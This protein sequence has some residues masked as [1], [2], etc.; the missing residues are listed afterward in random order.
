M[1]I[2]GSLRDLLVVELQILHQAESVLRKALPKIAKAASRPDI[3]ERLRTYQN[4]TEEQGKRLERALTLLE[5]TSRVRDCRAM[6]G[7]VGEA[8]EAIYQVGPN[9]VRDANL[10]GKTQRIAHYQMAAYAVAEVYARKIG[11]FEV[12]VLLALTQA[13]MA[14]ATRNLS[15]LAALSLDEAFQLIAKAAAGVARK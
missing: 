15:V 11:Q 1:P 3:R 8:E 2:I 10:I 7:L 13:E 14:E 4:E 9:A 12:A 5:A 6:V